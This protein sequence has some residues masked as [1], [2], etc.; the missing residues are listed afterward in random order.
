MGD[1]PESDIADTAG[2][3]VFLE[4]PDGCFHVVGGKRNNFLKRVR[5]PT[6]RGPVF[7]YDSRNRSR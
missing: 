6:N 4:A 2:V 1:R 3:A 5:A 7:P